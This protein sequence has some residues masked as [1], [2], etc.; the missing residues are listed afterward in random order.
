MYR[1]LTVSREF[2]SGGATIAAAVA[3][4]LKWK[5]LD[6]ALL[7]QIARCA[8]VDPNLA[9]RFDESVDPWLHRVSKQALWRGGLD[10]VAATNEDDCFDSEAMA[11]F[12]TQT[13]R[14]A[15]EIGNCVVVGR[16]AQCVLERRADTFHVFVYAPM[17]E[18]I[19]RVRE[20]M[21]SVRDPETLARET[22]R[23]RAAYI[24]EYFQRD[25]CDRRLYDLLLNSRCG[26][27][28]AA[29]AILS[30]AGLVL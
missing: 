26:Q 4:E 28:C 22:D 8:R 7:E 24:R 20:R 5:L 11:R 10:A 18:K 9:A 27:K 19:A 17:A 2:G 12:A 14:E 6:R 21:P 3:A 23:T 13:I 1:V 15:A 25:W 29:G 30:A 16:G